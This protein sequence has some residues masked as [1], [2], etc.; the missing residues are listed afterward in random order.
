MKWLI[1]FLCAP[2]MAMTPDRKTYVE[3]K[4]IHAVISLGICYTANE[5]GYPKT[6]VAIA[7]GLGLAKELYDKKHGGRFRVGDVAWTTMPGAT[8]TIA[9]RW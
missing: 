2:I 9:Y 5:M 8:L 1:P 7:F 3:H 4:A 6:G